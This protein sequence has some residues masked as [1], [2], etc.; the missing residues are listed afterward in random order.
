MSIQRKTNSKD[1]RYLWEI[2][3]FYLQRPDTVHK[4]ARQVYDSFEASSSTK[5]I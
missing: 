3:Y 5:N 1:L 2:G 4:Q